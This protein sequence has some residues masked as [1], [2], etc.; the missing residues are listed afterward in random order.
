MR[1]RVIASAGEATLQGEMWDWMNI[2]TNWTK[3]SFGRTVLDESVSTGTTV[4]DGLVVSAGWLQP[5][6]MEGMEDDHSA[7]YS[8]SR[9]PCPVWLVRRRAARGPRAF[10]AT[11][12]SAQRSPPPLVLLPAHVVE[13][14]AESGCSMRATATLRSRPRVPPARRSPVPDPRGSETADPQFCRVRIT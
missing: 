14:G 12:R 2:F 6:H 10:R 5:S 9:S 3:V 11:A 4:I 8:C 13:G 7:T 1:K